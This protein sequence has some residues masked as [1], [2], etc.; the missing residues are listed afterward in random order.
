[1]NETAI[2]SKTRRP[3]LWAT[4]AIVL[5]ML[6]AWLLPK[7]ADAMVLKVHGSLTIEAGDHFPWPDA[8]LTEEDT[9]EADLFFATDVSKIDTRIPGTYPVELNWKR[10]SFTA[11]VNIV[12][13]IAPTGAA[14]D[15]TVKA[16]E[17]PTAEDFITEVKDNTAV[18]VSFAA[19][20]D[21]TLE[22]DQEIH[23]L[24]TDAGGNT[25]ELTAV[26]TMIF[27]LEP[28]VIEGVEDYLVYEGGTV[29]YR[30]GITV[31]DNKDENPQLSIDNSAVDLST[32]GSYTVIFTATDYAG[33]TSSTSATVNVR[34]KLEG[35]VELDVIYAAVDE[36]LAKI[37]TED[38]T[39]R[40]KV[41][42]AANWIRGHCGFVGT[43]VK[44]DW[45]QAGYRMLTQRRGDCFNYFSLMKLMLERMDIPNIDVE[46]VQNHPKDSHH[47]WSL[48]SVDGGETYYH[49]DMT[50][51]ADPVNLLLVTDEFMDNYSAK[52]KN[53]FNRDTSLYPATPKEPLK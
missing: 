31:T 19:E 4:A 29:A 3:I 26:L 18:T 41:T 52:H 49:V 51:R 6:A 34:E 13:T 23:L 40:E 32:P 53:C 35:F 24:L 5:V 25:L 21:F 12:D 46:K 45:L 15:L 14:Q 44:D 17:I 16:P 11:Q 22:G 43:S 28:P 1:M 30:A 33:N 38:M 36:L 50:P 20:P 7:A 9:G 10:G 37:I 48:V 47:Y 2:K 27:D 8:F 39:D 42:A